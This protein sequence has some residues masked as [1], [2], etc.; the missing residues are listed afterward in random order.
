MKKTKQEVLKSLLAHRALRD[1][2][3]SEKIEKKTEKKSETPLNQSGVSGSI[4]EKEVETLCNNDKNESDDKEKEEEK[5]KE[6]E[7]EKEI[8]TDFETE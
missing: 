7:S 6:N 3:N 1:K 4:I 5:E 8:E 2:K